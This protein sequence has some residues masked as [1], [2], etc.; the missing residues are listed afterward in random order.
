MIAN[1]TAQA[2]AALMPRLAR[3]GGTALLSVLFILVLLSTLAA[4]TAADENLAIRRLTNQREYSQSLQ[5]AQ[6]GEMWA[7][8]E[9]ERDLQGS[10][11][12][13]QYDYLDENWAKLADAGAV[14][15]E[16]GE[17]FVLVEDLGGRFNLNN[18]L[19]GKKPQPGN[20]E[21]SED[22]API[23]IVP[24]PEGGEHSVDF[25]AAGGGGL[26]PGGDAGSGALKF[27]LW[28]SLFV[29]LL[30]TPAIDLDP[31]QALELA[32]NV[33]DWLDEDDKPTDKGAEDAYYQGFDVPYRAAN[34]Q[35]STVAELS[36]VKGF[37]PELVEVLRPY[38]TALPLK[39]KEGKNKTK[40][41]VGESVKQYEYTKINANTAPSVV[42][43]GLT[44]PPLD[45]VT[46]EQVVRSRAVT[47]F[48]NPAK[49]MAD[50]NINA[51][52]RPLIQQAVDVKS[53]F[54][55][56]TSC[57]KYGRVE[58]ALQSMVYR[59]RKSQE[60]RIIGRQRRYGCEQKNKDD[61]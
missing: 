18:L 11:A 8:R 25:I 39:E 31:N 28:Y 37:S 13:Q 42:L 16:D 50:M 44:E 38:I 4:F 19:M 24:S 26:P 17:M 49:V 10:G 58:M 7:M 61:G 46:L 45:A 40:G 55:E 35:F 57:A 29:R 3:Q 43:Q 15:V 54:Y 52:E 30:T 14:P 48:D 21:P 6:G 22:A 47:P 36:L 27:S 34:R 2:E 12:G 51:K 56:V 1:T 53:D 5:V 9:L 20:G 33:V 59:D 41:R 32:D 23:P 60:A